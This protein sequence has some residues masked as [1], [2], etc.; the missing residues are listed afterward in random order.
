VPGG[1][2]ETGD[3]WITAQN[4]R[5]GSCAFT[6]LAIHRLLA[7][8]ARTYQA[9]DVGPLLGG[10]C[11]WEHGSRHETIRP[12]AEITCHLPTPQHPHIV[13]ATVVAIVDPDPAFIQ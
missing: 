9:D 5:L 10:L 2:T 13:A 6:R 3:H 12:F 4:G 11:D 7:L 8:P 1:N